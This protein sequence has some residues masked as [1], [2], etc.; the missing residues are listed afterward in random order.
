MVNGEKDAGGVGGYN[1]LPDDKERPE[2]TPPPP[3]EEE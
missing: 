1:P 2:P 3:E